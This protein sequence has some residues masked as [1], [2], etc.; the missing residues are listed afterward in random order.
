MRRIVIR[1]VPRWR[2]KTVKVLFRSDKPIQA[3]IAKKL[4]DF[5]IRD[6]INLVDA[7]DTFTHI[8]RGCRR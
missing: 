4:E 5:S 8:M 3:A 1:K 7:F 2:R 6:I